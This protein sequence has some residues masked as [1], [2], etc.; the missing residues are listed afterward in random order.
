M[1][2]NEY[3]EFDMEEELETDPEFYETDFETRPSNN[4]NTDYVKW[5]QSMLNRIL[6]L[7][8]IV[9]GRMGPA[10]RS[11]IRSFQSKIGLKPD[12]V[13]NSDTKNAL[14]RTGTAQRTPVETSGTNVNWS[15]IPLDKRVIYVMNLLVNRYNLQVNA[16]SGIVGNLISE[17]EIIPNRVQGSNKATPMTAKNFQ[18]VIT[19]FSANEIMNRSEAKGIGPLLGG[20]G[21]AQWTEYY[22]RKRLFR[23]LFNGGQL[24]ANIIFDMNAQIDYLVYELQTNYRS[25]LNFLKTP[26]ITVNDASDEITYKFESPG[27]VFKSLKPLIFHPRNHPQVQAEFNRRRSNAKYAFEVYKEYMRNRIR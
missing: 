9:D 21:I 10:T 2:Y 23:H 5:V 6:G 12:G 1:R 7:R 16:A 17:S 22:R 14:V 20:I 18:G 8:L 13:I 4:Q 27:T 11:A 19:T 26:G 24:G 25:I 3:Q 15:K